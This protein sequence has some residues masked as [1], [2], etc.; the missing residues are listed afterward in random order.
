MNDRQLPRAREISRASKKKADPQ[1]PLPRAPLPAVPDNRPY[2]DRYLDETAPASIVGRMIKFSKE[3]A[4][5]V[6]LCDQTFVGWVKFPEDEAPI[7]VMGLL[8]DGFVM[9]PR[10]SLGDLDEKQWD[11]GLDGNPQDPWQH[12]EYLVLQNTDTRELFTFVTSSKTGRHA[13]GN[14]LRHYNRTRKD[15]PDELPV[16]RLK[17]SGF[18]HKDPRVGWVTTPM[19]VVVGRTT[20]DSAAKPDTSTGAF[21]DDKIPF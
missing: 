1:A 20:R 4:D 21:L 3:D 19:F 11:E 7:R 13:V 5:F 14:L 15:H 6:A 18:K 16:V 9:P 8:Y 12:H 17:T 10:D 2:V